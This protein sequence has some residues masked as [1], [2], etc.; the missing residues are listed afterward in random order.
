[1]HETVRSAIGRLEAG[2]WDA[3]H[4]LAQGDP[5]P[6]AAW[7]HAHL[8]RIEGDTANAAYWYRRAGR[9]PFPGNIA[10]EREAISR[11]VQE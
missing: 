7:L 3:A 6:E 8:H 9:A 10:A 1:M 5:S 4:D 11:A 2:D